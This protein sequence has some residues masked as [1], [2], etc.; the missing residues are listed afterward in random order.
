MRYLL[1]FSSVR[2][3]FL[4]F[5]G[6]HAKKEKKKKKNANGNTL[7][8]RYKCFN[9]IVSESMNKVYL[10]DETLFHQHPFALP[11]NKIFNGAS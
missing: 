1:L 11:Y 7:K 10:I 8:I 4:L 5:E 2:S 3:L 6:E 9:F